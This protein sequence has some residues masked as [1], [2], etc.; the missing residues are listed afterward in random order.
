MYPWTNEIA[1]VRSALSD[2]WVRLGAG[3]R[4]GGG[5][6]PGASAKGAREIEENI[7]KE[8]NKVG[9]YH[10][11]H[12]DS[13]ICSDSSKRTAAGGAQVWP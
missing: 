9:S 12:V 3:L 5:G 8:G 6:G 2:R 7:Q 4:D 11:S 1:D 13:L 10:S